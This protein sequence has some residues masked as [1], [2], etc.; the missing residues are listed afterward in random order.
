MP[1]V[2]V[3]S[4]DAYRDE[5][6]TARA[7]EQPRDPF[8]DEDAGVADPSEADHWALGLSLFGLVGQG[9]DLE[10][11]QIE[12]AVQHVAGYYDSDLRSITL[13]DRGPRMT[14]GIA[15]MSTLAHEFVH[16]LQDQEVGLRALSDRLSGSRD[17][18][19]SLGC[20]I[21]GEARLYE[22]LSLALLSGLAPDPGLW[23]LRLDGELKYSRRAVVTA[24][25]PYAELWGLRYPIGYRYLLDAWLSGGNDEVERIY[26]NLPPATIYWMH[27]YAA[28]QSL[29]APLLLPLACAYAVAPVHFLQ[30]DENS[31]GPFGLFA[32]LAVALRDD[33]VYRSQRQ[34]E[35]ALGWRQDTL[36]V[37]VRPGDGGVAAVWRIRLADSERTSELAT[38]LSDDMAGLSLSVDAHG[39]ELELRAASDPDVLQQWPASDPD[40]CPEAPEPLS[41]PPP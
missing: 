32:F 13:I 6:L 2:R 16:A 17:A 41:E 11:E 18:A 37:F 4:P 19:F 14:T 31:L 7:A 25:S 26:W 3:I 1:D 12:S 27:G 28:H 40:V 30:V 38:A 22:G 34:F 24:A 23:A 9:E 10:E 29:R 21:E 5:L 33:G 39:T 20:L 15:A 35:E 8:G 36:T